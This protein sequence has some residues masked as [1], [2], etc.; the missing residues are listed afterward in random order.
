MDK[1]KSLF[2]VSASAV[3]SFPAFAALTYDATEVLANITAIGTT[4]TAVMGGFITLAITIMFYRK[5]KGI[6]SRG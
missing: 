3:V 2:V 1:L 5:I 4:A 6:V